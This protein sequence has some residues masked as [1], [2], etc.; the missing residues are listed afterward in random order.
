MST[1]VATQQASR[2]TMPMTSVGMANGEAGNRIT[3]QNLG[4]V[5]KF[6][7]VMSRA[8]KMLPPHLQG[9]VGACMA[10]ALQAFEWEMNP[11][12]VA[13]KSYFVNQR[14]AYE[15]QLIAA[16]VNTR[17]G[18]EGRLRYEFE[19]EGN[20]L[21]CIVTGTLDGQECTYETPTFGQITTKN[22]P[23]WKSDPRQQLGYF[24]ARSWARR[25]CPEVLLGVYDREEA[26]TMKDVTPAQPQGTGLAA[27]LSGGSNGFNADNVGATLDATDSSGAAKEPET[28]QSPAEAETP[29][30][31][32]EDF[33]G[34]LPNA[35]GDVIEAKREGRRAFHAGEPREAP[36]DF[37][38]SEKTAWL[39][40]WDAEA[41]AM[42]AAAQ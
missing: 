41:D 2:E 25:H 5:V 28:N 37:T 32:F 40:A 23:L 26:A 35:D 16:V 7:E 38:D 21:K 8:G 17:S 9:D 14:V 1:E 10:V 34:D 18:I 30:R 36:D 33:P 31:D 19:G 24:A 12:A 20:T 11:F 42:E 29:A 27:R 15:A 3:P 6:A 39:M 13:S 22:S 4:E